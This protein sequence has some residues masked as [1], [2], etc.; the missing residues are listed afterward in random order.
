MSKDRASLARLVEEEFVHYWGTYPSTT[1][2][3]ALTADALID[4]R[5]GCIACVAAM[6]D[7]LVGFATVTFLHPAPT[8]SGAL[9]MK[10]LYVTSAHRGAG[11]GEKIMSWLSCFAKE[12]GCARFDWTA[13]APNAQALAFYDR[14]GAPRAEEKIYYRLSGASLAEAG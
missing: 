11:I 4:G 5:S 9:F 1:D 6:D 8:P 12:L 7:T 2:D 3:A 10:D 13:E 14:L